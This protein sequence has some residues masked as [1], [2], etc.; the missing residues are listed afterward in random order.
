MTALYMFPSFNPKYFENPL[1]FDPMRWIDKDFKIKKLENSFYFV[2]FF[3]GQRN[4][5]GM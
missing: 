3:A 1:K 4:C 2:P 5:I